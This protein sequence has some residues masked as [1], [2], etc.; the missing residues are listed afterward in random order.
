MLL[1][2]GDLDGSDSSPLYKFEFTYFLK[3]MTHVCPLVEKL[4][5]HDKYYSFRNICTAIKGCT[6]I[7]DSSP[8]LNLRVFFFF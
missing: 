2:W 5:R 3:K 8:S 4:F 1:C 7:R 6:Y